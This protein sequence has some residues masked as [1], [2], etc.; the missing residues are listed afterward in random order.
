M[1]LTPEFKKKLKACEPEIRDHVAYLQL[2][3]TKL[4]R[5][6]AKL[7]AVK[8]TSDN[9]VRALEKELKKSK[10]PAN[11]IVHTSSERLNKLMEE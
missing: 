8:I 10:P 5:R 9:R 3:N 7:E 6:I 4:Q 1:P 2:E 11:V